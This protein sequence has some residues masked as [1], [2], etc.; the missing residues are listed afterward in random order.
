MNQKKINNQIQI[1]KDASKSALINKE[2][3]KNFLVDAGIIKEDKME[4]KRKEIVLFKVF[5]SE[6]VLKPVNEVLMSGF[7]GQGKK[8]D[9]FEEL[10]KDRFNVDNIVTVNSATS[11]EHLAIHMLKDLMKPND[12]I[13]TTPMTCTATNWPIINNGLKLKWVDIDPRNLNMDLDDLARKI[14]EHTKII[15]LVHWGGYPVDLDKLKTILDKAEDMYGFRP[16]VIEDCAHS[17][18][19]R[20]NGKLIGTHGNM[21]TFSFQAIKHFTTVDGGILITPDSESYKRAKLLRWYGIEREGKRNDMRCE[22]DVEEAGYKF[23]MND[24][25]ATIGIHNLPHLDGIIEKHKSN[26]AYYD[27]ELQNVKGVTLLERDPR[28]ESSFWIYSLLVD[29][30]QAFMTKMKEKGIMVSQVHERNDK[31]TCVKEFRTQLPNL[32]KTI[33]KLI[34]IPVGWWVTQEDREYIVKTIKQGW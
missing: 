32:D 31:H 33:T 26:A 10:L 18:G 8:V 12:Y 14:N 15:M 24:V 34:S 27:K 29:N 9:E 2:T 5:M 3:A 28:M 13:L 20:F 16:V 30:K 19:S 21:S 17:M 4:E 6:D 23:H 7:I 25:N 11:A 22:L 1:I